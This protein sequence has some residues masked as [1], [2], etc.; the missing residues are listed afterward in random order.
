MEEIAKKLDEIKSDLQINIDQY[1][2]ENV[3]NSDS[4]DIPMSQIIDE[5]S[6]DESYFQTIYEPKP[7]EKVIG[8]IQL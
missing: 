4:N 3:D 2:F 8:K 5:L 7:F 6:K 1:D